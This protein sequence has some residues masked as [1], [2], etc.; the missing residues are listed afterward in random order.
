MRGKGKAEVYLGIKC[1]IKWNQARVK[2]DRKNKE[3]KKKM[4]RV[5]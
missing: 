4:S 5:A 2:E 3:K 1:K